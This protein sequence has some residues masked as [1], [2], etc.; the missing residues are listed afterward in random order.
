MPRGVKVDEP[1]QRQT[2]WAT[3]FQIGRSLSPS[4]YVD[5]MSNLNCS[6]TS[7]SSILLK[8][9][10][11]KKNVVVSPYD[12]L[13][14]KMK[15]SGSSSPTT[16]SISTSRKAS[17]ANSR[18]LD[19]S[20][21][22]SAVRRRVHTAPA[23][24]RLSTPTNRSGNNNSQTYENQ[25]GR[26]QTAPPQLVTEV[27][28]DLETNDGYET[29]S[30]SP[31]GTPVNSGAVARA[32]TPNITYIEDEE[33]PIIYSIDKTSGKPK[34]PPNIMV[35]TS[36][37]EHSP[38]SPCASTTS[39]SQPA[40][41]NNQGNSNSATP[42]NQKTSSSAFRLVNSG[43]NKTKPTKQLPNIN[44]KPAE[45]VFH[46]FKKPIFPS[47]S[48]QIAAEKLVMQE[49]RIYK[50]EQY[51]RA[52]SP[53]STPVSA[54]TTTGHTPACSGAGTRRGSAVRLQP[55]TSTSSPTFRPLSSPA[56]RYVVHIILFVLHFF[57]WF[58]CMYLFF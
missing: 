36:M 44:E 24:M 33:T 28:Q 38:N 5:R 57:D 47:T 42:T 31:L 10:L 43:S 30:C 18:V 54:L 48:C 52:M 6:I 7:M 9:Q 37:V 19:G 21:S 15:K 4:K 26:L 32:W 35:D 34:F 51:R 46:S 1:A 20:V 56:H 53:T 11:D 23:K 39:I 58:G 16:A 41:P 13:N 45:Q 12:S 29:I 2:G 17:P 40:N 3:N 25:R 50:Q 55:S 22:V 49:R 27:S 14:I 8:E